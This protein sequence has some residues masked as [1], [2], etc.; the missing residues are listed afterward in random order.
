MNVLIVVPWD[1]EFGGV[2]AVVG[3]LAVHLTNEGHQIFFLHPGRRESLVEKTTKWGFHCFELNLREPPTLRYPLFSTLAFLCFLPITLFQ[4]CRLLTKHHIDIVNIHY[5][6]D[7][8]FYFAIC[9]RFIPIKLVVS[10]HGA[11]FFP[12]GKP[13]LKTSS[14]M[15][16]LLW[17]ADSI[18]APSNAFLADFLKV[19]PQVRA[20]ATAIHNGVNTLEVQPAGQTDKSR[21]D[22]YVLC[23]AH[24]NEKKGLDVLIQAF[25]RISDLDSSLQLVLVGDGPL[26]ESLED[27]A[28]NLRIHHR[29]RFV[30]WKGRKEVA[31]LLQSCT[32][33]VLPSK[34][35]PFGI[36]LIEAMACRRPVI[37]SAVGGIPEI[38]EHGRNGLMVN[39]EDPSELAD[40]IAMLLQNAALRNTLAEAGYQ[41]VL[42]R[43]SREMM[44]GTYESLFTRLLSAA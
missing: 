10:V 39:P 29:A 21:G 36:V 9:R 7:A 1:Q 43:F 12:A 23:I 8:F 4:L 42:E 40:A 33:L 11:D 34:S 14:L 19:A 17:S 30:G 41:T 31:Q 24:H 3:N 37:A 27:L 32:M 2:A 38:I 28:R 44:G 15:K 35:E 25:A 6:G 22:H 26:R 13:K 5:P 16:L 18:V 20:R